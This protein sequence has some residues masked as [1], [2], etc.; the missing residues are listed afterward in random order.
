MER[1]GPVLACAVPAVNTAENGFRP[2]VASQ[3]AGAKL[4]CMPERFPWDFCGR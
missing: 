1:A 3:V 2:T 4:V